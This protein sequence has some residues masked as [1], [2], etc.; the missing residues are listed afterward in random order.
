MKKKKLEKK[1]NL[2]KKKKLEKKKTNLCGLRVFLWYIG[3]IQYIGHPQP[4]DR[5]QHGCTVG[6]NRDPPVW[7]FTQAGW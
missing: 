2:K 7:P 1:K 6:V 4:P 5:S 3:L